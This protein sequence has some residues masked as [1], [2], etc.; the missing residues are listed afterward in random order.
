MSLEH[1]EAKVPL[2]FALMMT[3]FAPSPS[4][5]PEQVHKTEAQGAAERVAGTNAVLTHLFDTLRAGPPNGQSLH[6][7]TRCS[8]NALESNIVKTL[9]DECGRA[10][11]SN[12]EQASLC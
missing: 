12:R 7:K 11:H 1:A 9:G 6:S 3:A 5:G 8:A 4:L 2:R 10:N